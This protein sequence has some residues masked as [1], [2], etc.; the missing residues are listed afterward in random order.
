[1]GLFA[2][3]LAAGVVQSLRVS[4]RLPAIDL[5]PNGSQAYIERLLARE[6]YDGAIEQLQMQARILPDDAGTHERLGKLLFRQGHPDEA[7]PHFQ[8]L[9]RLKP[10]DAHAFIG[11]GLTWVQLGELAEAEKCFAK[12]VELAPNSVEA[13]NLLDLARRELRGPDGAKKGD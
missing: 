2:V 1:V 5:L 4:G 13:Q 11:L 7:R 10:K 12:A 3:A 6:D 9:V 8:E